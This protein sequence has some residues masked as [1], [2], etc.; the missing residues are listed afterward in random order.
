MQS[1]CP[2]IASKTGAM[3]EV[4]GKAGLLV[5]PDSPE[6]MGQAILRLAEEPDLAR[7]LSQL[8]LAQAKKFSWEKAA[9]ETLTLFEQVT[10]KRH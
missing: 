3:P 5:D 2:V 7:Q 4:V 9:R 6:Q 10:E 1:G 8:G